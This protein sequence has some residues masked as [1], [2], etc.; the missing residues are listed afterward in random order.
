MK[1]PVG[2]II[3]SILY[4]ISFL[5]L[6]LFSLPYTQT[7]TAGWVLITIILLYVIIMI[8]GYL[9]L[10]KRG[11][12]MMIGFQSLYILLGLIVPL[13]RDYEQPIWILVLSS[14]ILIYTI[15]RKEYFLQKS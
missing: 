13:Y 2:V 3:I 4:I 6:L 5:A 10:K 15:I 12:W 14:L 11:F 8:S 9:N 7:S 1:R